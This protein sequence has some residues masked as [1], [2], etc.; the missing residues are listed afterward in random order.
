MPL[1]ELAARPVETVDRSCTLAE[2]ARLMVER[3]VGSLV[4]TDAGSK[5]PTGIVTDRDLVVLLA[6]GLDPQRDTVESLTDSPLETIRL[7]ERLQ[8]V[9]QK[10][11]KSGVRR[12]PIVDDE[13][14][15]AGIVSLDDVLV[16]LGR[17]MAD[18]AM[19]VESE[20]ERDRARTGGE[21][22]G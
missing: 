5:T 8:H 11:R 2:A 9:T 15:L 6:R 1:I 3:S 4:I 12:L 13:G 17:E 21:G 19:T 10:M 18:L 7:G 20:L 16:L 14:R 22:G